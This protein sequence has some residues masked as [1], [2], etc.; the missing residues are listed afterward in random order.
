MYFKKVVIVK[1]VGCN[2]FEVQLLNHV[3]ELK[4]KVF[5]TLFSRKKFEILKMY[6]MCNM[7]IYRLRVSKLG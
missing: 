6:L 4:E 3:S 5:C 1:E 7:K 2:L